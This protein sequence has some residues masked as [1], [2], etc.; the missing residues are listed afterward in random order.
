MKAADAFPMLDGPPISHE[1]A[2]EVY[3]L[4]CCLFGNCQTLAGIA[5]RGGFGHEEIGY[6]ETKHAKEK[7]AGRCSCTR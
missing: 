3:R 4:Y 2:T 6:I 5:Q 1:R 7:A